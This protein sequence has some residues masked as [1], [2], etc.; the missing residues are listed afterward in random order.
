MELDTAVQYLVIIVGAAAA[1]LL[2]DYLGYKIKRRL[3]AMI[4]AGVILLTIIVFTVYAAVY[5]L[6]HA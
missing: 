3:L 2:G 1:M 6:T 5:A 4:L